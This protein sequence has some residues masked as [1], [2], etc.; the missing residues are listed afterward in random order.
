MFLEQVNESLWS[1][2]FLPLFACCGLLLLPSFRLPAL[3]ISRGKDRNDAP[4]M[5]PWQAVSTAL[6]ATVGT[7]NIVGT[8]QAVAMGGPGAVFW[9]WCAAFLGCAVKYAEIYQGQRHGGAVGYIRAALGKIPAKCYAVLT[10]VSA[11]F[12]GNMAQMNAA[13]RALCG[14]AGERAVLLRLLLGL[15]LVGLLAVPIR[16]G[17]KAVGSSCE[18]LVPLMSALYLLV[19]GYA[20][21]RFRGRL[22]AVFGQ[23]LREAFHPRAALGAAGGLALRQTLLWGLRRGAFSNEAGLGSAANIH[24][25]V[26]S[27][28]PE[29]HAFWGVFEVFADS[30]VLCT[31]TALVLL[32]SGVRIPFGTL[33]GS[34]LLRDALAGIYGHGASYC[35]LS[36]AL[37][38]FG[39]S[40]VLGVYVCARRCVLWLGGERAE[41]MYSRVFL[42]CALLGC[43]LPL[44]LVWQLADTV[45]LLLS[46]PNLT[47]LILLS[48]STSRAF[49]AASGRKQGKATSDA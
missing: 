13:V 1:L 7:G 18:H 5:R 12:V 4:G 15:L 31:A 47:A 22:P 28:H 20:L 36:A 33:P 32:A 30:F 23:I 24:A 26:R 25:E 40:T 27:D 21:F 35:F 9:L 16:G 46:I 8:A 11:L 14:G 44:G 19:L 29:R 37:G 6:A 43:L 39:F 49:R 34:E 48:A 38:L 2:V 10:A 3:R 41:R 42:A 45:N 17:A